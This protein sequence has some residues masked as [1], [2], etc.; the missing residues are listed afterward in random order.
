MACRDTILLPIR[1]T[2]DV[3][4][5]VTCDINSAAVTVNDLSSVPV[6]STTGPLTVGAS[7]VPVIVTT[8]S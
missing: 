6:G 5:S 4:M 7:F 1:N 2:S 8:I 3:S